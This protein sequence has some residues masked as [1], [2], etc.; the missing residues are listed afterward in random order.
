M[1]VSNITG[2]ISNWRGRNIKDAVLQIGHTVCKDIYYWLN[3]HILHVWTQKFNTLPFV[4]CSIAKLCIHIRGMFV[5]QSTANMN[6]PFFKITF[7][8][9]PVASWSAICSHLIKYTWWR[10]TRKIIYE[11][12][13]KKCFRAILM[14][15]Y[16]FLDNF[17]I[18]FIVYL[19]E[20]LFFL[21]RYLFEIE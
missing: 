5:R 19:H 2:L 13:S 3:L 1:Y 14:A 16:S 10:N 9:S 11:L 21:W 7:T 4:Y 8:F 18:Y 15:I 12:L 20:L 6:K 17:K